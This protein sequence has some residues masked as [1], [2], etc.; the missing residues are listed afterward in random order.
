MDENS[1]QEDYEEQFV[2][3]DSKSRD[4]SDPSH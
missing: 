1:P 2:F 4:L 3:K